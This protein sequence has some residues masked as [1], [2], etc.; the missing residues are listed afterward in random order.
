MSIETM[1]LE[2]MNNYM[3]TGERPADF[4]VFWQ[5][6]L[7]E[8]VDIPTDYELKKADFQTDA[9][10]CWNL[11]YSSFDG[12][13]IHCKLA[14]PRTNEKLPV[15]F[16]YHGYKA[17]SMEW[18]HKAFLA[19]LGYCVVAMDVRGQGGESQDLTSGIGST[20][21]GQLI[22]GIEGDK[23]DMTF[24]KAY[25]DIICLVNLVRSFDFVDEGELAV[26]GGSQGGA[27]ALVTAALFPQVKKAAVMYPFLSDFRRA[28]ELDPRGSAYEEL[29]YA[30]R[31]NDPLHRREAEFF[32][33]LAY[34]DVKNFAPMIEA[35]V[36]MASGLKDEMCPV[37]T[38]FAV[39]N[40]LRCKKKHVIYPDFGH[41]DFLPGYLDEC[42][43][44][45]KR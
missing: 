38:H 12:S 23:E 30:F 13:R 24:L 33:K 19:S 17:S 1:P 16:F 28:Y 29:M 6:Q 4:E 20:S 8:L 25:K 27:L 18:W 32:E 34:I 41:D 15:L 35:E 45:L 10:E 22:A 21:I 40:N 11:Y 14:K 26:H 5:R 44:F 7:A 37:S 42:F 36:M 39:Y 3:G 43:L 9:V 2:K 31:F